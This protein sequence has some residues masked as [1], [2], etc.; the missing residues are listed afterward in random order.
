MTT[1]TS[2]IPAIPST[3]RVYRPVLV[4]IERA[5]EALYLPYEAVVEAVEAG[6]LL[7]VWDIA[8][9][10][11]RR[12]LRF[13]LGEL[14]MPRHH[15]DMELPQVLR[16]LDPGDPEFPLHPLAVAD[17]LAIRVTTVYRFI[18]TGTIEAVSTDSGLRIPRYALHRFLTDRWI[19]GRA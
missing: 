13:W 15:R 3:H 11:S 1:A 12:E 9:T 18:R 2:P 16:L 4:P 17:I 6:A 14:L 19:G 5:M 10:R 8:Q 7:W